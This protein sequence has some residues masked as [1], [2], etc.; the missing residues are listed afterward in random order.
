[1]Y[2]MEPKS[3]LEILEIFSTFVIDGSLSRNSIFLE[4]VLRQNAHLVYCS[5]VKA[6]Q[7]KVVRR[8]KIALVQISKKKRYI[9]FPTCYDLKKSNN[10]QASKQH[11]AL[12][13]SG[14]RNPRTML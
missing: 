2:E 10:N 14:R 4:S 11:F 12:L 3:F 1:M 6:Q 7:D 8:E 13:P 5:K 9:A